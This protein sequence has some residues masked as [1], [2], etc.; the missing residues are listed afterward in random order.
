VLWPAGPAFAQ[1]PATPAPAAPAVKVDGQLFTEYTYT[2]APRASD[3]SGRLIPPN[4]FNITRAYITLQGNVAPRLSY[5]LTADAAR[6]NGTGASLA[7]SLE[8]R[9][10]YAFLQYGLGP[11]LGPDAWV[12]FGVQH[13]PFIDAVETIY[14]YRFEGTLFTERDAA[15][16]GSDAGV[17]MHVDLP[18]GHGDL[19]GGLFNGEGG[20]HLEANDQKS[21]QFRATY[22]PAPA[23]PLMKGF[24]LQ[25]FI[26]DDHY[27][28]D[29]PKRRMLSSMYFEHRRF[30]A[31]FDVLMARDQLTPDLP[32]ID[33]RGLSM[34]VT[35]FFREKGNGPE[36]LL[37]FDRFRLDLQGPALRHRIIAGLAWWF[38]VEG[39]R[40]AAIMIDYEQLTTLGAAIPVPQSR[41]LGVHAMMHF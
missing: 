11:R 36:M 9:I 23:Y 25:Y 30:N 22:K 4:A 33:G 24:R 18:A 38:P 31:G 1:A 40:P 37:R 8:L 3:A 21:L 19:H 35:P 20:S 17:T 6:E 27:E 15:M 32:R 29:A 7:G 2:F 34:W 39:G 41:R 13:T 12:R 28:R 5:R 14:R 26:N 10:K 16:S